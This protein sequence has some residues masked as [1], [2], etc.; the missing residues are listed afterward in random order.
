MKRLGDKLIFL[1]LFPV[2]FSTTL[3][4][5]FALCKKIFIYLSIFLFLAVLGFHCWAQAFSSCRERFF[6]AVHR[7]LIVVPSLFR[8]TGSGVWAQ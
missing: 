5:L 8:S 4:P 7:L 3:R 6:T 2:M 1:A